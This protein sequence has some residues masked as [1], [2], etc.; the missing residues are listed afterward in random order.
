MSDASGYVGEFLKEITI[1][2]RMV[3]A[4]EEPLGNMS[5]IRVYSYS[6]SSVALQLRSLIRVGRGSKAR[7]A[8]ITALLTDSEL[9]ELR[10]YLT[11]L[12]AIRAE[13]RP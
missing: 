5:H 6:P 12:I 4:K 3:G 2:G 8:H 10:D 11:D 13:R 9:V 7:Q 1:Q